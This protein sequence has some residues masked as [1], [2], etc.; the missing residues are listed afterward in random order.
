[1]AEQG[2]EAQRGLEC[3]PGKGRQAA[4]RHTGGVG[5]ICAP[6]TSS[7]GTD[8]GEHMDWQDEPLEPLALHMTM[9]KTTRS[10]CHWGQEGCRGAVL[11][12]P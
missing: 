2:V 5:L 10:H 9:G 3:V 7:G 12:S 8:A 11:L 6:S 4:L 1:M